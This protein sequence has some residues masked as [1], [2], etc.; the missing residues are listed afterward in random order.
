MHLKPLDDW[1]AYTNLCELQVF[2]LMWP[3]KPVTIMFYS[4]PVITKHVPVR[5]PRLSNVNTFELEY[6][7]K[8]GV[9]FSLRIPLRIPLRILLKTLFEFM[10]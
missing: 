2:G 8:F 7:E 6:P 4:S 5:Y 1:P 3:F 9:E 10:I